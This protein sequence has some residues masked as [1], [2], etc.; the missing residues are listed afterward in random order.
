[1]QSSKTD[2]GTLTLQ[3]KIVLFFY[4]HSEPDS[5]LVYAKKGLD[6]ARETENKK[7]EADFLQWYGIIYHYKSFYELALENFQ[8]SI[9]IYESIGYKKGVATSL[10]NIGSIYFDDLGDF[11]KALDY[12]SQALEIKNELGEKTSVALNYS[13]IG[14]C[15]IELKDFKKA[16]DNLILAKNIY[17]GLDDKDGMAR[18]YNILGYYYAKQN[19]DAEALSYRQKALQLAKENENQW[20]ETR[21][22]I[23]LGEIYRKQKQFD[24]SIAVYQ[25]ALANSRNIDYLIGQLDTY[26]GLYKT[27]FDQGKYDSAIHYLTRFDAIKDTL[28]RRELD[29][30]IGEMQV[31]YETEKKEREIAKLNAENV[32]ADLLLSKRNNQVLWISGSSL[33]LLAILLIFYGRYRQQQ[34]RKMAQKEI[35]L[36]TLEKKQQVELLNTI[37]TTQEEERT[38]L[39]INLH[40]GLGQMLTAAKINLALCLSS[41]EVNESNGPLSKNIQTAADMVQKALTESKNIATDLLPVNIAGTGLLTGIQEICDNNNAANPVLKINFYSSGV[42]DELPGIIKIN[43]FRISQE[44]I[45]NVI[46]HA[47]ATTADLQIF[48]RDDTLVVQMVDNGKGID[49]NTKD[50]SGIGLKSIETRVKL[51]GG[52]MELDSSAGSGTT[53]TIHIPLENKSSL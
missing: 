51:L 3:M 9:K 29:N 17:E 24:H 31:K 36:K 13:N 45:T 11:A 44:L 37:V 18:T 19:N 14:N 22:F 46:K 52:T 5:A 40:D 34:F 4:S 53:F 21:S 16:Y 15:H 12:Y 7:R 20:I 25:N 26:E 6:L 42:P 49:A 35:E 50:K 43:I 32:R 1:M 23:G 10:N 27:Y 28:K 30:R 48:F 38:K 33:L 47:E 41:H 8:A 2:T 39:S